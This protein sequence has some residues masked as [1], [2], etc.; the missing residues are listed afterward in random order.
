MPGGGNFQL[1]V[2]VALQ[3]AA[4]KSRRPGV[5][6]RRDAVRTRWP[7]AGRW[8]CYRLVLPAKAVPVIEGQRR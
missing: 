2:S 8:R 7:R 3:H 1:T 5:F 4:W 6:F